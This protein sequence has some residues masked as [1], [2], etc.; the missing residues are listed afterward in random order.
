MTLY[1]LDVQRLHTLLDAKRHSAYYP[2]RH[3]VARRLDM[4]PSTFSRLTTGLI[5]PADQEADR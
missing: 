1:R 3:D 2:S 4:A 5:R